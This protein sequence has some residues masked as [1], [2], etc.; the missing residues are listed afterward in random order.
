MSDNEF[1]TDSEDLILVALSSRTERALEATDFII[2]DQDQGFSETGLR[3]SSIVRCGKVI[4][5][6][7][8]LVIMQL[9]TF[10]APLMAKIN[11]HLA[12]A[13]GLI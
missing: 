3:V 5:M 9:G 6:H 13:L 10:N 7:R 1:N 2:S 12:K 8:S 11:S 4:T